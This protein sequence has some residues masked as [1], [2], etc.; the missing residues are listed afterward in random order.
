MVDTFQGCLKEAGD[1]IIPI[2]K[3]DYTREE[4]HAEL[5]EILLGEKHGR[6]ADNQLTLFKSVGIAFE[7]LQ[8]GRLAYHGAKKKR[9]GIEICLTD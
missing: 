7:D 8:A 3:G 1:L 5:G 9:I 2:E 4:I 6:S